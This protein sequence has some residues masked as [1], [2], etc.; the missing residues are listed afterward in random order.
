MKISGHAGTCN[1]QPA[2]VDQLQEVKVEADLQMETGLIYHIAGTNPNEVA[3]WDRA[4]LIAVFPLGA[5]SNE[6]GIRE[7]T[8]S[9]PAVLRSRDTDVFTGR[10]FN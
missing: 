4:G 1:I 5:S 6:R 9:S 7:Q 3:N 2:K 8:Y 10:R